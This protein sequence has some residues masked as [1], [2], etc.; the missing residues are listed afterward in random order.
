MA[1][2]RSC[3]G[4]ESGRLGM[5]TV[6]RP[7]QTGPT[8]TVIFPYVRIRAVRQ[9]CANRLRVPPTSGGAQRQ[10]SAPIPLLST[11][12]KAPAASSRRTIAASPFTEAA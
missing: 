2:A 6:V 12:G 7:L 4:E 1:G 3:L 8:S 5:R 10:A 9:Q 11:P